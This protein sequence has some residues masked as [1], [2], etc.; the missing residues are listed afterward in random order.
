MDK[1]N[2]GRIPPILGFEHI[3]ILDSKWFPLHMFQ[4]N[5]YLNL[6]DIRVMGIVI[7]W[8][9]VTNE[10]YAYIG[11]AKGDNLIEDENLIAA[12]GTKYHEYD[13]DKIETI[14]KLK[15]LV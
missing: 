4:A 8:D 10:S 9:D 12:C 2:I 13:R 1:K 3:H 15:G 11:V 7:C 14:L 5:N 6:G